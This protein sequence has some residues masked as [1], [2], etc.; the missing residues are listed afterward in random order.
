MKSTV[1]SADRRAGFTVIE[2]IV[3]ISLIAVLLAIS[4]P[5]L[6]GYMPE[7]QI[8]RVSTRIKAELKAARMRAM[9]TGVPALVDFNADSHTYTIWSDINEDGVT[10]SGEVVSHNLADD[11][12]ASFSVYNSDHG[13]F[14]PAG[15]FEVL[16]KNMNLLYTMIKH[17]DTDAYNLLVVGPSGQVSRYEYN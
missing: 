2:L 8:D 14:T 9:S 11:G 15:F 12:S 4:L 1:N 10:N 17:A 6:F 13:R 5:M 16:D 7:H 3:S